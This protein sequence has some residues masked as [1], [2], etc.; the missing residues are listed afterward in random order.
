MPLIYNPPVIPKGPIK[1]PGPVGIVLTVISFILQL[2]GLGSSNTKVLER[3]INTTWTNLSTSAAFLYNAI[4]GVT[5][6]LKRFFAILI[7]G[8]K[9]IISDILHG[10]LLNIIKDVRDTLHTLHIL[11]QPILDAL[12]WLHKIYYK[13]IFKWVVLVQDILS[14]VRVTLAVFRILGAKW[15]AKLD[16]DIQ[17]IQG[18]VTLVMSDITKTLNTVTSWVQIAFD[19]AGIVRKDF[20]T[21]TLFGSL[22]SV[23]AASEFGQ[24][25]PLFASE[26][27]DTEQDRAMIHGGAAI[28]TRN[29]DGSVKYSD[30]SARMNSRFDE[31]WNSYGPTPQI[32]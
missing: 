19:P 30:A 28:L 24:D 15:A 7:D 6:W 18:Y 17:R 25:R 12:D 11:F 21:G 27:R 20:F 9:H 26:A 31:A 32:H 29:S 16:A 4:S 10:H 2:L 8:L 23:R 3:A 1:I 13:Y 14:R 5:D 22:Q